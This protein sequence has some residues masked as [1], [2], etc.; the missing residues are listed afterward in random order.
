[1]DGSQAEVHG[2]TFAVRR[3]LLSGFRGGGL[4]VPAVSAGRATA[5]LT[6]PCRRHEVVLDVAA[7]AALERLRPLLA[8]LCFGAVG[9]GSLLL[10]DH[11]LTLGGVLLRG[12]VRDAW[13]RD[14]NCV[15]A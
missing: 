12:G 10:S 15:K 8:S 14:L 9:G 7:F 4:S 5:R 2:E 13:Q 11:G 3:R 6:L 1:M